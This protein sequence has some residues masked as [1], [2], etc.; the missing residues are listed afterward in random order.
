MF[1]YAALATLLLAFTAIVKIAVTK[2]DAM[3]LHRTGGRS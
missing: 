1:I 2:A 3:Q